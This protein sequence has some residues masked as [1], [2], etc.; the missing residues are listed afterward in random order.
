[1]KVLV[2]SA[3]P[4]DERFLREANQ[5]QHELHFVETRLER[6]TVILAKDF[7]VICGFV[8][9]DL[10]APVLRQLVKG[11]TR[12]I[13]LRSTGF[14]NVDLEAA[15]RLGLTVMRVAAYSPYSIAEFA[16]GIILSLNRKIHRAY[17]RVRDNNFLL[18]GLLGF[19]LHGKTVGVVGTGKI[20]AVFSQIMHGFGCHLLGYDLRQKPE[21][22]ALGMRY[23]SLNELLSQ[24]DI[25]SLHIPLTPETYHLINHETIAFLKEGAMLINTSRGALI[26][27][28]V[29]IPSLKRGRL[30]AVGLDV[31][32]EESHLYFRDLSDKILQDDVIARLIT[33]PNVLITGH[34]AFFTREAETEIAA[35]VVQN[36]S[37]F[38]SGRTNANTLKAE[39]VLVSS[40]YK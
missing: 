31:Y 18:D 9:D 28:R 38:A 16:V 4:Y 3:R 37:D 25:I 29:L 39:K 14:N 11:K 23:T 27:A 1:M 17:Q 36:I 8:E 32:E 35:T 7:P 20:G 15:D 21:L 10:S 24:S 2:Y 19:D 22:I 12:L 34:Q 30:S 5:G 33:F 13:T 40:R 6:Q 26:D